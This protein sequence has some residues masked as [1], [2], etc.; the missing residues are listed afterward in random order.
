MDNIFIECFYNLSNFNNLTNSNLI[1]EKAKR[2]KK[3][4]SKRESVD[5][6]DEYDERFAEIKRHTQD[7]IT[8][9]EC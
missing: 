6:E 8:I 1:M 2:N 4:K 9:I 7:S 5:N 3:K